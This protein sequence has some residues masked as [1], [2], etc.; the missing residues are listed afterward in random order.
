MTLNFFCH[1]LG[2]KIFAGA[3][4]ATCAPDLSSRYLRYREIGVLVLAALGFSLV[5]L[6]NFAGHAIDGS[7]HIARTVAGSLLLIKA[8]R[9]SGR[10][11]SACLCHQEAGGI[12]IPVET[13]ADH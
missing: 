6:A 2:D 4:L 10:L 13:E 5:L 8:N 7:I 3:V 12:P 9:D 11:S 1:G